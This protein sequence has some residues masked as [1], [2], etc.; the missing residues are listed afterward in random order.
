[1]Q[2][3]RL[4]NQKTIKIVS[5]DQAVL[6][7]GGVITNNQSTLPPNCYIVPMVVLDKPL[8]VSTPKKKKRYRR[9]AG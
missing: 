9:G 3:T 4:K 6:V 2:Q 7:P 8:P 1:M 5:E